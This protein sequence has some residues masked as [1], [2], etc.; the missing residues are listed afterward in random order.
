M[1][2]VIVVG[3]GPA[4]ARGRAVLI[5]DACG[6]VDRFLGEGIYYAVRSGQIA[7]SVIYDALASAEPDLSPYGTQLNR[8][9]Y[10]DL[11]ASTRLSSIIYGNSRLWYHIL[12]SDPQIMHRYFEV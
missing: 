9:L 3:Q 6:L 8:E 10:S 1:Y 4:V 11:A 12:E 7:A 2:D 5:G